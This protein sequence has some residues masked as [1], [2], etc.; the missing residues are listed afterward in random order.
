[1]AAQP[2]LFKKLP[3]EL[4]K[5]FDPVSPI[6]QTYFFVTVPTSSNWK[7][8]GDLLAAAK[9]KPDALDYGSWSI[10]SPGHIGGAILE[11]MSGTQML[12]VP[13]KEMSQLY[14]GVANKEV[15][16][17]FGSA[18]SSGAMY[19]A[20]KIRYLAAAAPKRIEGFPDVP[21]VA[22]SGGPA[23]FE[24]NSWVGL[25]APK[26]TPKAI[27]DKIQKDMAAIMQE[28]EIRAKYALNFYEPYTLTTDQ[29]PVR[30][31]ADAQ[32]FGE[33]IK[34]LNITLD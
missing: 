6:F 26:G 15:G 5:D 22:E 34:R 16:W 27:A 31:R 4:F 23:G 21:T 19:R 32:R 10:G 12:H 14:T 8:I 11:G 33:T 29:F 1:M 2:F 25:L 30:V 13:F 20:G 9:A 24:L 18:A 28:P 7:N 3:Y 17:A